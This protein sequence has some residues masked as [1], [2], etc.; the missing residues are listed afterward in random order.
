MTLAGFERAA[1]AVGLAVRG[2]LHPAPDPSLPE[3]TGTLLM[4]GPDEPA[5]WPLFAAAP[6]ARDGR[7]DPL[8]RWSARVVGGLAAD[9]GGAAILPSDGPPY[10]P[11][12]AWAQ[13]SG[14]AHVAP[15]G[16]LVH[17]E[18]GLLLSFRGAVAL[19]DR[20]ER[21]APPQCPCETC[22]ARPCETACP[23]GAMGPGQAYDVPACRAFVA[24]PEG[25]DC[26]TRGCLV[27]RACPVSAQMHRP[28]DQAAF[29]MAAFLGQ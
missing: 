12:I 16:L 18:A 7:P 14:R 15:V 19:R 8:D 24:S 27:R 3:D 2:V 22:A 21:P 20:I 10:P 23:V 25:V 11:F 26:R 5:F 28:G 17:D 1:R 4:L 9:W 29:H 6:E 13:Q